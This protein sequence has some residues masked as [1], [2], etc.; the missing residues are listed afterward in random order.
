MMQLVTV[1][2]SLRSTGTLSLPR[3]LMPRQRYALP[4]W[5]GT[6]YSTQRL[7]QSFAALMAQAFSCLALHPVVM[8]IAVLATLHG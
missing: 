1:Y 8:L 6:K 5:R 2:V 7:V 3:R 4:Y